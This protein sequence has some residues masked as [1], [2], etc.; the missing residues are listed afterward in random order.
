MMRPGWKTSEFWLSTAAQVLGAVMAS[1]AVPG[2]VV[3]QIAGAALA[4]L[5]ALG[6]TAGRVAVKRPKDLL[7]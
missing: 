3:A 4:A 1:G 6:Y 2:G 5:S 7:P